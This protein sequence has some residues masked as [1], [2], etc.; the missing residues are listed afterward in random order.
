M[1]ENV[2]NLEVVLADGKV[3]RT[4]GSSRAR[5]TSAG[6]N[7]TNLFIVG[8]LSLLADQKRKLTFYYYY[9]WCLQGSEG[10]LGVI[11]QVTLKLHPVPQFVNVAICNFSSVKDAVEAV[12][13]VRRTGVPI[14]RVEFLDDS[15]MAAVNSYS[16]TN[17]DVTPGNLFFEFH[18]SS[19]TE[20]SEQVDIVSSIAQD[21]N[22][23]MW[24][25]ATEPEE[26]AKLWQARHNGKILSSQI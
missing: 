10:T 13:D 8:L 18:G 3:I 11:T 22:R 23:T 5:K 25:W 4:A 14:A 17:F 7:L 19:S 20:V 1:R 9:L 26:R 6:Y 2:L 21:H 12:I 15:M 16:H 24:R